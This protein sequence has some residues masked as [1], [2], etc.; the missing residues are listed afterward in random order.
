MTVKKFLKI[1]LGLSVTAALLIGAFTP[2]T[3]WW[4]KVGGIR[5]ERIHVRSEIDGAV[6]E[7]N[8]TIPSMLNV[9]VKSQAIDY[10]ITKTVTNQDLWVNLSGPHSR[11]S[12]WA[13]RSNQAGLH[14]SIKKGYPSVWK[15]GYRKS[16]GAA[17][18]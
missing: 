13:W 8:V 14:V 9:S 4:V 11:Q 6:Q 10:W 5:G 16:E 12:Y 18:R 1:V 7:T 17:T 2:P 3:H 15:M